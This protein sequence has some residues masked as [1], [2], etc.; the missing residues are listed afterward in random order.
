MDKQITGTDGESRNRLYMYV[1]MTFD[2]SKKV[3]W[4]GVDF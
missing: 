3:S 2:K 4:W 1:T